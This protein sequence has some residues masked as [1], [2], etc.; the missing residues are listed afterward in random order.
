[1]CRNHQTVLCPHCGRDSYLS[2]WEKGK[3]RWCG[4]PVNEDKNIKDQ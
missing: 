1:M 4:K 3:C 2:L